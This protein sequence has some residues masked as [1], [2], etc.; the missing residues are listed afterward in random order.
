MALIWS[1]HSRSSG[2]RLLPARGSFER[3]CA[4]TGLRPRATPA[5]MVARSAVRL[6]L[7]QLYHGC[8][9]LGLGLGHGSDE[10]Q[11]RVP[12]SLR[13]F[14]RLLIPGSF[15][16]VPDHLWRCFFI[17]I[18]DMGRHGHSGRNFPCLDAHPVQPIQFL[19]QIPT[20]KEA[21]Y[22]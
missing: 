5:R 22:K 13:T 17:T 9:V 4:N 1:L 2:S 3:A 19:G 15:A 14:G 21:G 8:L 11:V 20:Q 16:H 6:R 7:Q 12:L 18:G 10:F